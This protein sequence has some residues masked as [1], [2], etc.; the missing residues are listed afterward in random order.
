MLSNRELGDYSLREQCP[1]DGAPNAVVRRQLA[2]G[3]NGVVDL[4]LC[5]VC[6]GLLGSEGFYR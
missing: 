4:G 6:Q 2:P 5:W 3:S 1:Q